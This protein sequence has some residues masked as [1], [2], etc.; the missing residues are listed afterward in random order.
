MSQPDPITVYLDTQDYSR[1]GKVVDGKG[2]PE[3]DELFERLKDLRAKGLA[4]FVYSATILSEL[5]Q[6]EAEYERETLAKA[7]AVEELCGGSTL[8]WLP[9]LIEAQANAFGRSIGLDLPNAAPAP[10]RSGNE[11]FP[12]VSGQLDNF[13]ETLRQ[14]FDDAADNYGQLN[15]AQ[16]RAVGANKRDGKLAAAVRAIVPQF[17]DKYGISPG[18]VERAI[19]PLLKGKCTGDEA[20]TLLFAAVAK[21]TAFIHAFFKLEKR[22][23][24]VLNFIVEFGRTLEK[25]LIDFRRN[26]EPFMAKKERADYLRTLLKRDIGRVAATILGMSDTDEAEQGVTSDVLQQNA[27]HADAVE[28]IPCCA[29]ATKV[30]LGYLEQTVAIHTTP[31]KIEGSF[32]GDLI[33][34]LY[35]DCVDIWR[36]DSR[37]A[38]LVRQRLRD[39]AHKN[40][41]R[42]HALPEHIISV[43]KARALG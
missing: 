31:S 6:Y 4:R 12:R 17:A 33:H 29:I 10:I 41:P 26:A 36:T 42:L 22:D 38:E 20:S 3:D 13:K 28:K 7:R 16:R 15:R 23:K 34:V 39:R 11:W 43:S 8:I 2:C 21:P 32:G 37:F 30:M 24:S 27:D 1:F 19:I 14:G 9:R 40:Q 25:S 35:I 18:S 5:L